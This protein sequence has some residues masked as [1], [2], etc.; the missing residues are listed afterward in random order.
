MSVNKKKWLS[1]CVSWEVEKKVQLVGNWRKR[2]SVK[3]DWGKKA[4]GDARRGA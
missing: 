4:F 1:V 3:G 2:G